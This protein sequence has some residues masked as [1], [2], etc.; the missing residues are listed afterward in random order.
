MNAAQDAYISKLEA[1]LRAV[2]D[3]HEV[4][5][6]LVALLNTHTP[7]RPRPGT[8][9]YSQEK[10]SRQFQDPEWAERVLRS[11]TE[12]KQYRKWNAV[13]EE[14]GIQSRIAITQLF[15]GAVHTIGGS[16]TFCEFRMALFEKEAVIPRFCQDCFKVQ[17]VPA[18]LL[19]HVQTYLALRILKLPRDNTRKSMVEIRTDVAAPYKSYIFC[20]SEA[21]AILCRDRLQQVLQQFGVTAVETRITHGC[22][23]YGNKFPAFKYSNDGSHRSFTRP[24]DWDAKEAEFG[25]ANE[26]LKLPGAVFNKNGLSVRDIIGLSTWID[27]AELI[28]DDTYKSFRDRPNSKKPAAFA[29]EIVRQSV[30]RKQQLEELKAKLA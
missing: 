17:A 3:D 13:L 28:G 12:S 25:K 18:N 19:A 20:E 23:E 10:L 6:H 30:M 22:S 15:A 7:D 2:P 8:Y 16:A 21:E 14:T 26:K 24:A 27:Y 5:R 9:G 4:I 29:E 11:G 1:R